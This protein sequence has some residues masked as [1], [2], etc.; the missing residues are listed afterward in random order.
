MKVATLNA[1]LTTNTSSFVAGFDRADKRIKASQ[2]L[3]N[4]SLKQTTNAFGVFGKGVTGILGSL[5]TAHALLAGIA[6]GG[7]VLFAKGALDAA[8]AL[9]DTSDRLQISTD[10]LQ[11]YQYA[12]KLAGLS[13]EELESAVTKLNAKIADGDLKYKSTT[14]AIDSIAEAVR[15]AKTDFE[16]AAIINDAFGAKMGA[17]LLPL[18][19]DGAAGLRAL[20]DEAQRTGNVIGGDV[21]DKAEELGDEIEAFFGT[22]KNNIQGGFLETL[23]DQTGELRDVYADPDFAANMRAV[24]E[25]IGFI[26]EKAIEALGFFG[27][28]IRKYQELDEAGKKLLENLDKRAGFGDNPFKLPKDKYSMKSEPYGPPVPA[29][30]VPP[31]VTTDANKAA[32]AAAKKA[33]EAQAKRIEQADAIIKGLRAETL[34]LVLQND[35]SGKKSS[36]IDREVRAAKIRNQLAEQGITLSAAQ[37]AE[38]QKYLNLLEKETEIQKDLQ[39]QQQLNKQYSDDFGKSLRTSLEDAIVEGKELSDV[40]MDLE[41][42][43]AKIFLNKFILDPIADAFDS[44]GAGGGDFF[45]GIGKFLGLNS[46]A[47]GTPYVPSDQIA[48]IHKGEMIIPADEAAAMRRG[49]G[50]S[51]PVAI[52]IVNNAGAKVSASSKKGKSGGIDIDVLIAES[53]AAGIGTP[54]STISKALEA[55]GNRSLT[56]R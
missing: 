1:D 16:R 42:A 47:V 35:L 21:I 29:G 8:G 23:G 34:E 37:E 17:K 24:G 9:K 22:I 27:G 11:K 20:G 48:Q 7:F 41:K 56:R 6:T 13:N 46:F 12:A 38:L 19:K 26:T 5:G 33:G 10:Q 51:G 25:A 3:W 15:T 36:L 54:G 2:N 50:G 18:L 40:L 45:S 52:N 32:E 31:Y 14:E 28:L 49:G 44:G 30:G 53:V 55:R 43:I 4:N 39:K